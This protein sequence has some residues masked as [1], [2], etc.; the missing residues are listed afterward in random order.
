MKLKKALLSLIL[1]LATTTSGWCA[2]Q[3]AEIRSW[4]QIVQSSAQT[5]QSYME[6]MQMSG[7]AAQSISTAAMPQL[8]SFFC[9]SAS[10]YGFCAADMATLGTLVPVLPLLV[11]L[12]LRES[13]DAAC[14]DGVQQLMAKVSTLPAEMETIP[15]SLTQSV[16]TLSCSR[17]RGSGWRGV[18]SI[19]RGMWVSLQI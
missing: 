11:S 8:L 9:R 15:K 1:L 19:L 4:I 12:R 16:P 14:A 10:P 7:S 6:I 18:S 3:P 13:S 2:L 5:T 17:I